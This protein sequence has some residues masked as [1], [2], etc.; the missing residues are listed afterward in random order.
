M[1]MGGG[2]VGCGFWRG[3]LGDLKWMI[4]RYPSQINGATIIRQFQMG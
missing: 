1:G 2:W 3:L 4:D